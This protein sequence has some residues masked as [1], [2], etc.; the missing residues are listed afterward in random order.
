MRD[1]LVTIVGQLG[2]AYD[3]ERLYV[4][5]LAGRGSEITWNQILAQRTAHKQRA[6]LAIVS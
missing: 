2:F 5:L 4:R 1:P 3:G 6:R